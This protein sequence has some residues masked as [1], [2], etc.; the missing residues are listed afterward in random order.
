[1]LPL[2]KNDSPSKYTLPLKTGRLILR[3]FLRRDWETWYT[4]YNTP[5]SHTYNRS[6]P[7]ATEK[8][9]KEDVS[10]FLAQQKEIPRNH[11]MLIIT[12]AETRESMGYIYLELF[13]GYSKGIGE[14]RYGILPSYWGKGYMSEAA[15][16]MIQFGFEYLKLHRI[17]AGC[18]AHNTGSYRVME[19]AGMTREGTLRSMLMVSPGEWH[20]DYEYGIIETDPYEQVLI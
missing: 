11:Y 19:K 14:L 1:M 5:E 10:R 18:S 6:S 4:Y 15:R 9:A 2:K 7:G 13:T 20:D 3:D 8:Q 17:Q 16:A 12:N